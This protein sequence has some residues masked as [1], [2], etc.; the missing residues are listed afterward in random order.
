[1]DL[2][3][4]SNVLPISPSRLALP[5]E[6]VDVNDGVPAG[7]PSKVALLPP[8]WTSPFTS[9]RPRPSVRRDGVIG[10]MCVH[11]CAALVR[12]S[13]LTADA[14]IMPRASSPR[15]PH[16]NTINLETPPRYAR[17]LS[18]LGPRHRRGRCRV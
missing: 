8:R 1:M 17:C 4:P 2:R 3:R 6:H 13:G 12:R 18:R 16:G 7:R 9:I 5:V 15:S 10:N 14:D 11:E